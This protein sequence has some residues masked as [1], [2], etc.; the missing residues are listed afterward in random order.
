MNL[1]KPPPVEKLDP[2][3]AEELRRAAVRGAYKALRPK[4]WV[5]VVAA[6]CGIAVIAVG[7]VLLDRPGSPSPAPTPAGPG[8]TA[9]QPNGVIAEPSPKNLPPGSMDLGAA[10]AADA[11]AAA[12]KCLANKQS[13]D[14]GINRSVPADADTADL[15]DIRWI[16]SFG[17]PGKTRSLVQSFTTT[18]GWYLCLDTELLKTSKPDRSDVTGLSRT[19][20]IVGINL[21]GQVGNGVLEEYAFVTIPEVARVELRVTWKGGASPWSSVTVPDRA[22][23]VAALQPNL[24][25]DDATVEIRALD[26]NGKVL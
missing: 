9:T 3:Y 21:K 25:R 15:R 23:Y 12:R 4:K 7:A 24:K 5:P 20:P 2:E 22:G 8:P 19:S 10:G 11:R 17:T 18:H 14:G 16:K 1:L 6:A 13:I 26:R